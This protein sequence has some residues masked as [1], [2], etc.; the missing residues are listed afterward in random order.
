MILPTAFVPH[1]GYLSLIASS[2]VEGIYVGERYQKQTLRNRMELLTASGREHF[3]VPVCRIGYPSPLVSKVLISEHGD[4]RRKLLYMLESSYKASP[5]WLHY[6]ER[7]LSLIF[8]HE[9]NL[10]LYNHRWLEM[11]CDA[12][13]LN[14]PPL[15]HSEGEDFRPE[16]IDPSYFNKLFTPKRYWQVFESKYGFQ[17]FLSSIDL[18]L[19][20]GPEA[21]LYFQNLK[22]VN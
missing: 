8:L 11:L 4:W 15:V 7:I 16:V 9:P 19:S 2:Q 18:L 12:M 13:G 14:L 3:T 20:L 1:V 17:P 6:E 10:V 22:G 21:R 5:Y